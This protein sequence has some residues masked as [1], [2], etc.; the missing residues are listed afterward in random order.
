MIVPASHTFYLA[1]SS[2]GQACQWGSANAKRLLMPAARTAGAIPPADLARSAGGEL[3]HGDLT[4]REALIMGMDCCGG[5][6]FEG[7]SADYK[8]R[9]WIVIA[10]N[11]AMFLV[12]MGAGALAGSQAL[13][14]DALDF[15]ADA[16]T[17]GHQPRGHRCIRS[18]PGACGLRERHQP[19]ANGLMGVWG[20]GLS[21]AR[22]RRTP[23]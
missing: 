19:H 15:L 2:S 1:C 6:T 9:L 21:R 5:A 12:E 10:I 11:A 4:K 3:Q 22:A 23:R 8:R 13:Q 17:Y 7:L 18:G 16:A 20:D 14:A